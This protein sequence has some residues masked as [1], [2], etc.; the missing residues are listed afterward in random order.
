MER[1]VLIDL[2]LIC[3]SEPLGQVVVHVGSTP[4]HLDG[5][6]DSRLENFGDMDG[7]A[8]VLMGRTEY[9][10]GVRMGLQGK[11]EQ[12]WRES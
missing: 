7:M 4:L 2:P 5:G 9:I 10:F 3:F 8:H 6:L 11:P 1:R 12:R